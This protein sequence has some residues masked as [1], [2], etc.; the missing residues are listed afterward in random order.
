MLNCFFSIFISSFSFSISFKNISCHS[1]CF[2]SSIA[3]FI[4]FSNSTSLSIFS[5]ANL[6]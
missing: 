1:I 2:I 6:T 4:L 3:F 5:E